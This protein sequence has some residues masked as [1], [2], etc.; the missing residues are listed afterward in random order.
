MWRYEIKSGN[1]TYLGSGSDF[2]DAEKRAFEKVKDLKGTVHIWYEGG[3]SVKQATG[4]FE[5]ALVNEG[6]KQTLD[7]I[8]NDPKTQEVLDRLGSDYDADGIA[9]WDNDFKKP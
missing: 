3:K 1:S 8:V 7:E 2:D 9:Y 5:D 6:F 4:T